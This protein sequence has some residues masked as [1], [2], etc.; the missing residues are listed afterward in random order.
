MSSEESDEDW[1]FNWMGKPKWHVVIT[2][3]DDETEVEQHDKCDIC[4]NVEQD[5]SLA[6]KDEMIGVH[7]QTT[8][9]VTTGVEPQVDQTNLT[10]GVQDEHC[11]ENASPGQ[12]NV[13]VDFNWDEPTVNESNECDYNSDEPI[14]DQ[15]DHI[16]FN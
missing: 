2:K 14:V 11:N 1:D 13:N 12:Y 3:L 16:E 9:D 5:V 4:S 15:S 6:L 8:Y 10:T 7:D